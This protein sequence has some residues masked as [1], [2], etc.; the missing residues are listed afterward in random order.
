VGVGDDVAVGVDQ[1]AGSGC[2]ATAAFF[3]Q[4][5]GADFLFRLQLRA[6]ERDALAVTAVDLVDQVAGAFFGASVDDRGS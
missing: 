4:A 6:D 1:E 5:E 2:G 3:G